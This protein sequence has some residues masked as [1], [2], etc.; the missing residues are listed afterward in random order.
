M[1][2]LLFPVFSSFSVG[3]VALYP[4]PL[5]IC[6]SVSIYNFENILYFVFQEQKAKFLCIYTGAF[7]LFSYIF[8]TLISQSGIPVSMGG[9]L[10]NLSGDSSP[11]FMS[12]LGASVMPHNFY[13][14]SSLVKVRLLPEHFFSS[15]HILFQL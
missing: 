2:A 13:L 3:F 4:S 10:I 1:D 15:A 5:H 12:L 6:I 11:A 9:T 8:G 14:H 7:M